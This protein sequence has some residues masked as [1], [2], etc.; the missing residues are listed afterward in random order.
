MENE[1][2]ELMEAIKSD[3]IKWKARTYRAFGRAFDP[4]ADAQVK[5]FCEDMSYSVGKS[6]IKIISDGSVWGSENCW[7]CERCF[8]AWTQYKRRDLQ[9]K[10]GGGQETPR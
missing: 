1:I 6:Y 10:M 3:Y 5:K 4:D 2:K 8:S 7:N 9:L